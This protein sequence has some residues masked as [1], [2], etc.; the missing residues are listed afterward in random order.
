M[1]DV[2]G[3]HHAPFLLMQSRDTR[4]HSLN[5]HTHSLAWADPDLQIH[6]VSVDIKAWYPKQQTY[7]F[8][9]FLMVDLSAFV[10][11]PI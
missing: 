3:F 5:T 9:T 10:A 6:S 7:N 11:S 4:I 8:Q 2:S 1:A